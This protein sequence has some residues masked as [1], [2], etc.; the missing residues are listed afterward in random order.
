MI[1]T[2]DKLQE[3]VRVLDYLTERDVIVVP[4]Q[5]SSM[6]ED[7]NIEDDMGEE[8]IPM[9]EDPNVDM[10]MEGESNEPNIDALMQ[11]LQQADPDTIEAV[12]KYAEG[13]IDSQGGEEEMP[14]EEDMDMEEDPNMEM[15]ED[16]NATPTQ[17]TESRNIEEVINDYL[18]T[19]YEKEFVPT[20]SK[21]IGNVDKNSLKSKMFNPL[22]K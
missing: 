18:D 2:K 8:E 15:E 12:K 17:Q 6:E 5:D 9:E 22:K 20:V 14:T 10:N 7:P 21:N 4:S 19:K 1:T 16:P 11:I 13:I 3:A